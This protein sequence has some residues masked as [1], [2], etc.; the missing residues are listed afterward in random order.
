MKV[1]IYTRLSTGKQETENQ[2]ELLREFAA[3]QGWT[4]H[5]GHEFTDVVKGSKS[6]RDGPNF[7]RMFDAASRREFDLVLFGRWIGSRAKAS[8]LLCTTCNA[9]T[10]TEW[11]G[12][13]TPS[14]T[15]TPQACSRTRLSPSWR[16]SQS[17]KT[18][19]GRS[20]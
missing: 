3:K 8:C 17:R 15:S 14:S 10:V 20:V 4:I 13:P 12:G 7:K 1:A 5:D 6:E 11:R 9:S 19:A 2:A 16:P 18:S